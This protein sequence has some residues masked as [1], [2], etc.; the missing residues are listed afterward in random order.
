MRKAI[1]LLISGLLA[2]ASGCGKGNF[3]GTSTAIP[4]YTPTGLTPTAGDK[5]VSLTWSTVSTARSYTVYYA[6]Q[7]GLVKNSGTKLSASG[8]SFTVTGLTNGTPYYF[9]VTAL[10]DAGESAP[11]SEVTATPVPPAP[12]AP[13][14]L[15]ATAGPDQVMLSWATSTDATSYNVY[16]SGSSTIT[17][18]TGT[19]IS[20]ITAPPE[21][22]TGLTA[23]TTYYFIVTAVNA[24]GESPASTVA[25]ATPAGRGTALTPGTAAT[26]TVAFDAA[27]SLTFNFPAD[28]VSSPATVDIT[29]AAQDALPV[30][31]GRKNRAHAAAMP[32]VK[33]TDTFIVAFQLTIDPTTIT[34]FNVPVGV[35]GTVDPTVSAAGT[36]L[37]LAIV[38][39][40]KWVD[41]ATFVVGAHGALSE[42]LPSTA[43]RGLLGPG[44][45]QLYKPAK[46]TSTSVSNLGI[47][48]IADDGMGMGDGQNG[49]EI[50]H[51]Y[52]NRGNLLS[53]PVISY[54][55]Y[56][57][58]SDL[59][60]A[61]LTPDGSQGIMVDGSDKLS[62]FSGAQTGIPVASTNSLDISNWGYDGDSVGIMPN[63]DEAVVSLDSDNSLL[64]VSGIVSGKPVAADIIAV[65]DYRDGVVVSG[66][67]KVMLARGGS[68]LTVFSVAD[69]T[70]VTGSI[71]GAIAHSYTQVTDIAA[72]GA[73]W[74]IEDGRDGMAISPVD[75]SRAV[76]L[77]PATDSVQLVT[78]LPANPAATPSFQLPSGAFPMAVSI[79]PDGK[80]AV[81]GTEYQGLFLLSGVDTGTL[82]LVGTAY[83]PSYTLGGSSVTLGR[84]TTLGITLDGKY[85]V[86]GDQDNEALVV[87][88][89]TAAGFADAPASVLGNV[90]IPDNDQFLI[91]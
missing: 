31:M 28:A 21:T 30:P 17:T 19:K 62:F 58:Q 74:G 16:Y 83:A 67:G 72:M 44:T 66:D 11:S 79:S 25:S 56:P 15:T 12:A 88:P 4:L 35:S 47:V 80:L 85:V 22:V 73:G 52:D 50:V 14:G 9:V 69:I 89:F 26:A 34:Q 82:N 54:L 38:S 1:F 71:G 24:G 57:N 37:N 84:I 2:I 87:V 27:N 64:V 75:S 46:G 23:G 63:G 78:G 13:T 76:L 42:N 48:L 45:Y 77:F 53:T 81:V 65:P 5:Q 39:G 70:P 68:G 51:L 6:T 33:A 40:Q 43:L 7:S 55:D 10:G 29:A 86:A 61:A 36:T 91:H 20:G 8:A 49:L 18:G 3:Q 59:D 41:I 90:A 32:Q 60:G